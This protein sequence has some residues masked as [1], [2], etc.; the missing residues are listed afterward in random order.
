MEI[1]HKKEKQKRTYL[2]NATG[3]WWCCWWKCSAGSTDL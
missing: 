2:Y 1:K 3:E